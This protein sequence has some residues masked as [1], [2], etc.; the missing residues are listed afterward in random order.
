MIKIFTKISVSPPCIVGSSR[1]GLLKN[2]TNKMSK[3]ILL[4]TPFI[5]PASPAIKNQFFFSLS[6]GGGRMGEAF[7]AIPYLTVQT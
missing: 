6:C 1:P 4:V 5:D 2:I 3:M 7:Q